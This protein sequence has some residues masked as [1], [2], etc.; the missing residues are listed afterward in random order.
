VAAEIIVD[1]WSTEHYAVDNEMNKHDRIKEMLVTLA[2]AIEMSEEANS[3]FTVKIH[4]TVLRDAID[5]IEMWKLI[6]DE[7][8]KSITITQGEIKPK[9]AVD[10]ERFLA[11]Q[12][13]YKQEADAVQQ[14]I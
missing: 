6:A 4:S 3:E 14:G 9:I 2:E 13:T 8:A 10:I 11:A 7:F 1:L 5:E 12:W